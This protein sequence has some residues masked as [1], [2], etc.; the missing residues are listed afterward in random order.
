MQ[1]LNKALRLNHPIKH[2]W[3]RG[4]WMHLQRERER[5]DLPSG[6]KRRAPGGCD[7]EGASGRRRSRPWTTPAQKFHNPTKVQSEPH[8]PK[9]S[10]PRMNTNLSNRSS[11][12]SPWLNWEPASKDSLAHGAAAGLEEGGATWTWLYRRV[13]AII[14]CSSTSPGIESTLSRVLACH[15]CAWIFTS[16]LWCAMCIV[17]PLTKKKSQFTWRVENCATRPVQSGNWIGSVLPPIDL[18]VHARP[19]RPQCG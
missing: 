2:Q 4:V 1:P 7:G 3:I 9:S 6:P 11:P 5:E 12:R 18:V 17:G 8:P 14:V 19:G 15:L 13:L 16:V 10:H